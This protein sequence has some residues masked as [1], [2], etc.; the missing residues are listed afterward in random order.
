[1]ASDEQMRSAIKKH[2][3]NRKNWEARVDKMPARQVAAI[4]NRLLSTNKL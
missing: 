3:R 2:Y 1:M 4:Y